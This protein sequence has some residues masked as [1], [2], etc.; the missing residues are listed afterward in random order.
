VIMMSENLHAAICGRQNNLKLQMLVDAKSLGGIWQS[1]IR[2]KA[3]EELFPM[4]QRAPS[5]VVCRENAPRSK[6]MC[7]RDPKIAVPNCPNSP[8]LQL[9]ISPHSLNGIGRSMARWKALDKPV[10]TSY[11][12]LRLVEY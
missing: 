12:M 3:L 2:W 10:P 8:K 6:L 4:N 7:A 5:L 11:S 9:P 1:W